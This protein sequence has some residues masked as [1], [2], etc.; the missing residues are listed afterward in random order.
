M[1]IIVCVKQVPDTE[2]KVRV[3]SDGSGIETSDIKWILNPYDSFA[4][5]EALKL[6]DK[7]GD[8]SVVT[9]MTVGPKSRAN[10]VLVSA[11][12]MGADNAVVV[13]HAEF[14]DSNS[15][16]KA[17]AE[18]IKKEQNWGVVF[19]GKQ[20]IDD[21]CAQVS[22]LLAQYLG[23]PH[24]TVAV[25][26]ELSGDKQ[27]AT[28]EREVEGGSKEVVELKFPAVIGAEKGLNAP[29]F[30]SLPGIMKAKKKPIKE[31]AF[32][33]LGIAPTE[34]KISYKN[35]QLPPP[36]PAGKFIEG[37]AAAQAS[38]LV[39]LLHEEAKVV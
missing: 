3:K 24:T 21:D 33:S 35:F 15:A 30:A 17:L 7:L 20:A 11:M 6:R 16:A 2:T 26:F 39:K 9:A 19:T 31:Y 12:G 1:N 27:S 37:D 28:V 10:D 29:R 8:G 18:A 32:S 14:L 4:I 5:E 38:T 25:K 23:A 36:R 13:D 34:Q 22:Q